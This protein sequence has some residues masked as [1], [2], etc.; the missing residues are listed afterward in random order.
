MLLEKNIPMIYYQQMYASHNWCD[1]EL[2]KDNVIIF[3]GSEINHFIKKLEFFM[4]IWKFLKASIFLLQQ[5]KEIL[6]EKFNFNGEL[7]KPE[8]LI[9][10]YQNSN[11]EET[12]KGAKEWGL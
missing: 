10:Y 9:R 5:R 11:K 7:I 2:R 4:H 3:M 12:E 8:E 1:K 6:Q